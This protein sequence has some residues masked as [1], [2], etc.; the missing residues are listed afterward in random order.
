MIR[1]SSAKYMS[2]DNI[3]DI[4]KGTM[5]GYFYEKLLAQSRGTVLADEMMHT[6]RLGTLMRTPI[7]T[8]T[9]FKICKK[10]RFYEKH[11]AIS[12]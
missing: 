1:I 11:L 12:R 7:R 4:F 5:L 2:Y 3:F 8:H 6:W 10:N 9:G